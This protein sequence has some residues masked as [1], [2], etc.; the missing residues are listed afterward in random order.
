[1]R[2]FPGDKYSTK[3]DAQD[4]ILKAGFWEDMIDGMVSTIEID[5]QW[6]VT[7]PHYEPYEE[8]SQ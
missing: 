2:I 4:A 3:A 5:G 7:S 8:V 1:M 6:I